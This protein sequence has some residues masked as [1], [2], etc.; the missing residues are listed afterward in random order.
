M[1]PDKYSDIREGRLDTESMA[2]LIRKEGSIVFDAT[3]PYADIVS[4]NIRSACEISGAE[5][6]R[7]YRPEIT[8]C[9]T[10]EIR[11]F[12]N[13]EACAAALKGSSGNIL[14]TTGSKELSFFAADPQVKERLYVRVLP[15]EESIRMC[16]EAGITG[17]QVIA[18]QGPFSADLNSAL[19]RQFAIRIMVTKSSGRAG[20]LP[21][22]LRA[23]AEAGAAVYLIGRP[24]QESGITV[25]EA[26]E[27]YFA[28]ETDRSRYI[29]V[30]LVG[31]G[32]GDE[33]QMTYSAAEAVRSAEIIFGADRMVH[34]YTDR[35]TYPYYRAQDIIPVIEKKCPQRIAVLFSGDTGFSS[36]AVR[37]RKELSAWLDVNSYRYDINTLPGI[38]SIAY[39]AAAAGEDYTC[40]GLISLHGKSD[41]RLAAADLIRTVR[42]RNKTFV[43]LSGYKDVK[44]LGHMLNDNNLSNTL[45]TIGFQLSYDNEEIYQITPDE[46]DSVERQGLYIALITNPEPEDKLLLPVLSDTGFIRDKVPMTKESVR[47]L[48][49]IK[50]GLSR[51][52]VLYDIGSGTG[53]VACEAVG[54]DESVK[55]YAIEMKEQA[56]ALI[57]ANASALGLSN[58]NVI[59]GRAPEAM[60]GLEPPTHAFIGGS[61]GNLKN[62]LDALPDGTRTVINA[63]SLETIAEIQS[64]IREYETEDLSVEQISVS[65]SR[66]LGSYHLMTAENPVM[67]ASFVFRGKAGQ[68][69]DKQ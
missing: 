15:S 44:K 36:G 51:G 35:S 28:S 52:S 59:E 12:D 38:S 27:K 5:Y 22:K 25:Q 2:D 33:S 67:I 69:G 56:C 64:V 63:V 1:H 11:C 9:E 29:H 16:S 32:P 24:E 45:I 46:C 61:S 41:D 10:Q 42:G 66:E 53:S 19:M 65:R 26:C 57:R 40:A 34:P 20:G 23:A 43:L 21:E 47:H 4:A 3:H 62:I 17:R 49:I 6:V 54:L 8:G 31:I 30:D 37:M 18:M 39:F 68:T 60:T 14:L 48:S 58:I 7:I 55:V 50:L 13:A